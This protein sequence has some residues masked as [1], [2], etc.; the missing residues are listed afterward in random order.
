LRK[1]GSKTYCEKP[2]QFEI[3]MLRESFLFPGFG[4]FFPGFGGFF[5]EFKMK[6]T[7]FLKF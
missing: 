6:I 2:V 4:G 7:N 3:A 5:L 1:T